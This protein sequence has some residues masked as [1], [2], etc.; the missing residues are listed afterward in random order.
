MPEGLRD[1]NP[2]GE[3]AQPDEGLVEE[4]NPPRLPGP[5]GETPFLTTGVVPSP[6]AEY[7]QRRGLPRP[8]SETD[9]DVKDA[10]RRPC[11]LPRSARIDRQVVGH[12]D[13]AGRQKITLIIRHR[14][15]WIDEKTGGRKNQNEFQLW[16][17]TKTTNTQPFFQEGSMFRRRWTPLEISW[18]LRRYPE[19][20]PILLALDLGRSEDSVSSM[21]GRLGLRSEHRRARQAQ[22]LRRR[23]QRLNRQKRM[24]AVSNKRAG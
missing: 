18:L 5:P 6:P 19:E 10:G 15:G 1:R 12:H 23:L 24:S 7:G 3:D 20:G 8:P 17:G 22:T 11:P 13:D 21:A 16:R 9:K 4:E 2:T 14:Q